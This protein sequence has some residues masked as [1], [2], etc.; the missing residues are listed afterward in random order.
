MGRGRGPDPPPPRSV[1]KYPTCICRIRSTITSSIPFLFPSPYHPCHRSILL[2]RSVHIPLS[3]LSLLL[4]LSSFLASDTQI[5]IDAPHH[6]PVHPPQTLLHM[7][8]PLNGSVSLST[9]ISFMTI[10]K[11]K[12]TRCTP[13]RNGSSFSPFSSHFLTFPPQGS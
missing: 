1:A 12:A 6:V 4:L 9:L 13:S 10:S 11:L 2:L 3:P 5:A 7:I 8:P